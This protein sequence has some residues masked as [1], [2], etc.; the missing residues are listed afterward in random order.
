MGVFQYT[1]RTE[2]RKIAE[3]NVNTD[4]TESKSR[5]KTLYI[6]RYFHFA[7]VLFHFYPKKKN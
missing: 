6:L 1:L 5:K 4:L 7:K 2:L 3:L